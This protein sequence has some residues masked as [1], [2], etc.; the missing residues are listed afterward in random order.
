MAAVPGVNFTEEETKALKELL[1]FEKEISE[2]AKHTYDSFQKTLGSIESRLSV[3]AKQRIA[4]Y[5]VFT[6]EGERRLRKE[7][8]RT[9]E[10]LKHLKLSHRLMANIQQDSKALRDVV[11]AKDTH[12]FLKKAGG[13]LTKQ[14]T[15]DKM[16]LADRNFGAN[17]I[18]HYM[19]KF[20]ITKP[21]TEGPSSQDTRYKWEQGNLLNAARMSSEDIERGALLEGMLGKG[22]G[23]E[24]TSILSEIAEGKTRRTREI[25][26]WKNRQQRDASG[27]F[28]VGN[29]LGRRGGT[30]DIPYSGGKSIDEEA[31]K[32]GHKKGPLHPTAA[33]VANLPANYAAG[34]L[35]IADKLDSLSGTGGKEKKAGGGLLSKLPWEVPVG[36][37]LSPIALANSIVNGLAGLLGGALSLALSALPLA[38]AS[39]VAGKLLKIPQLDLVNDLQKALP[40]NSPVRGL[41]DRIF[42]EISST[43]SVPPGSAPWGTT[44]NTA[45]RTGDMVRATKAGG[46]IIGETGLVNMHKGEIVLS[47]N[48]SATFSKNLQKLVAS[49]AR[50]KEDSST[51]TTAKMEELIAKLHADLVAELKKNNELTKQGVDAAN[52]EPDNRRAIESP[53]RDYVVTP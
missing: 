41:L 11:M 14:Y 36:L 23:N 9:D 52:R 26:N 8:A 7:D 5:R 18:D 4:D 31:S 39:T 2:N 22:K 6:K 44:G 12:N 33:F 35:L 28:M 53:S 32:L 45:V 10:L 50:E 38:I 48:E 46:G 47:P 37:A 29:T 3:D 51:F 24:Y 13:E 21:Y 25:T 1:R 16:A 20:A 27:R 34:S 15:R 40:Q 30:E 42:P 49:E 17:L 19:K 43:P